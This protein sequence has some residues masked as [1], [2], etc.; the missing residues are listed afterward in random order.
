MMKEGNGW[1]S[2]GRASR[3]PSD[4]TFFQGDWQT[5]LPAVIGLLCSTDSTVPIFVGKSPS[6]LGY[7]AKKVNVH[8]EVIFLCSLNPPTY[9]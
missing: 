5:I 3:S 4:I 1:E 9:H 7:H 8:Q 6:N 2:H